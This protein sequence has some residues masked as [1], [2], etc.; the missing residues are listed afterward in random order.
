MVEAPGFGQLCLQMPWIGIPEHRRS[1]SYVTLWHTT[2][3]QALGMLRQE[4][5]QNLKPGG[6][7]EFK[8][9]LNYI[10]SP[11]CLGN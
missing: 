9:S 7:A 10:A 6:F 11:S 5:L 8:A 3:I 2:I 1:Y 4:D